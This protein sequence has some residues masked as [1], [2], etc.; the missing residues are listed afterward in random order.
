MIDLVDAV[1][2][3]HPLL[4]TVPEHELVGALA[5]AA[6]MPTTRTFRFAESTLRLSD[7]AD[8]DWHRLLDELAREDA[9]LQRQ[10]ST[11]AGPVLYFGMA[12]I[13]I[14]LELGRRL[15]PTRRIVAHQQHHATKCWR[16]TAAGPTVNAR[17]EGV[18]GAVSPARGDVVIRVSCSH[19]VLTDDIRLVVPYP[20]AELVVQV[21]GPHE[22]VL[23]SEA[24]VTLVASKFGEAL[25]AIARY[26]P[27]CETIH[28]FA[29]VPPALA[30]RMGA[31]INP[32]I[33]AKP[34][35]TYQY[36]NAR[37]P[38]YSRAIV[39]GQR[40][41]PALTS[42]ERQLADSAR[43]ALRRSLA[44]VRAVAEVELDSE[45]WI[46]DLVGPAGAKL[47][48]AL[49]RLGPLGRN[50]TIVDADI[51]DEREANGEFRWDP[52]ARRWVLDDRLLAALGARLGSAEVEAAG[53]LFFLHEAIHVAK[54][55]ISS[56]NAD[57][58]GR[59][60]RVLEEVDYLADVWALVN[61]F[62]RAVRAGDTDAASAAAFFRE[63]LRVMTATFWTFDAADLPLST[64][65][66]RRLNRYLIWYWIRI[67]L[68]SVDDLDG[69]MRL[70]GAKPT[71]ELSGP[72]VRVLDGRVVFDLD[73]VYFDGVELGLLHD[74]YRMVRV[75]TRAGA[76]VQS[77][78]HAVRS[79]DETSFLAALR[80]VFES[81][82]S[83]HGTMTSLRSP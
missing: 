45:T 35:Q 13:P 58:V 73:P 27:N 2:I 8:A 30:V 55:G 22:D 31:E 39:L 71:L 67:A 51:A 5:P 47:S 57:R 48:P 34:I 19:P 6:W 59:L 75:G 18:P 49:R 24:D 38:R 23:Q 32:T 17:L 72:R 14:A 16:W 53:R 63:Q 83:D 81:V 21:D 52:E 80:G 33:H 40:A 42:G 70:L 60:P 26:F 11:T 79:G 61:D 54:Q 20:I 9:E 37:S 12:P 44:A 78:L 76:E 36:A 65:P 82:A 3:V 74:G 1:V 66:V 69:V 56:A 4:A 46:E 15:G 68:D 7:L 41:R 43:A 25:D 10:L 29:A 64:I 50:R 77:L 28:L 62:G